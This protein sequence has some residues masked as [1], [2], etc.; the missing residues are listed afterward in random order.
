MTQIRIAI[1]T[2][3]EPAA[4]DPVRYF[5]K[6]DWQRLDWTGTLKRP[7]LPEVFRCG[8]YDDALNGH[9]TK[10]NLEWQFFWL[11][12]CAKVVF[13]RLHEKLTRDEYRWLSLRLTSV[14]GDDTAFTNNHGLDKYRNYL[15]NDNMEMTED[16]AIY[17]LI[18]GGASLG[19]AEVGGMLK[20][21]HFD[22]T[23]PP[24]D[25]RT[26]DPY[27][28]PRVFFAV[29]VGKRADNSF[30]V[31]RFAQ[32]AGKDVPIPLIALR[33]IYF[34]LRDLERYEAAQ[35]RTPYYP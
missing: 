13:G 8:D 29:S 26:I 30:M 31:Y 17:T 9:Y 19:G 21:S 15:L 14:G 23:L 25:V 28:D 16:P 20:V 7:S 27:T 24:P 5:V 2:K 12:L 18:C 3:A 33:D 10:L 1:T 4:A 34:P 32:F 11:D 6:H 35:K 22:G